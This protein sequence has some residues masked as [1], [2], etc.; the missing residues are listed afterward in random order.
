MLPWAQGT[1]SKPSGL[2]LPTFDL[3]DDDDDL[4][5]W[6]I[7]H[8]SAKSVTPATISASSTAKK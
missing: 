6:K 4:I 2:S 8:K 1:Q 5:D 3:H 7:S